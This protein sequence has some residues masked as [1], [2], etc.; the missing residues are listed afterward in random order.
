MK[1][2]EMASNHPEDQHVNENG[3]GVKEPDGEKVV[4]SEGEQVPWWKRIW[5]FVVGQWLTIGFGL[6]CLL[7]HFFP[8]ELSP[9]PYS[10]P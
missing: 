8:C 5:R 4:N 2:R 9:S 7:A 1:P 3:R 6:A 10:H